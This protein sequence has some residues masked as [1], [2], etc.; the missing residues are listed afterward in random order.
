MAKN[1]IQLSPVDAVLR[2][3]EIHNRI[4]LYLIGAIDEKAWTAVPMGGKGRTIAALFAHIHSVRLMWL[5]ATKQ[6]LPDA[7]E[8]DATR[9]QA[10]KALEASAES[11]AKLV[12]PALESDGRIPNFKP[13]GWAFVGYLI[14]HE[15]HHRGQVMM[16]ARQTGFPV[17][18]KQVSA[19]GSSELVDE[20]SN[21]VF[22]LNCRISQK[23]EA[24]HFRKG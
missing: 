12:K 8:K 6:P 21:T 22:G 19:C 3:F 11:I 9:A 4:H 20:Q 16:V 23:C 24:N 1:E 17:D 14:A 2:S 18:K 15:A 5:K 13:D 7:L 10:Q